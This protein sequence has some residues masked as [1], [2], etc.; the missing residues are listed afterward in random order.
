MAPQNTENKPTT[1]LLNKWLYNIEH[2][3]E[4]ILDG[5]QSNY[6]LIINKYFNSMN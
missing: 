6:I 5:I 2:P 3:C 1:M 4:I